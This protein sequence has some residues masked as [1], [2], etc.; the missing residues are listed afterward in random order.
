MSTPRLHLIDASGYIY[1]AFFSLPEMTNPA[2]QAVNA[3]YGFTRMIVSLVQRVEREGDGSGPDYLAAVFDPPG[4]RGNNF[5]REIDPNY[6]AARAP[7]KPELAGQFDLVREAAE[8]L[9][10]PVLGVDGF[11]ADDVLA[12]YAEEGRNS[13]LSVVVV[14]PDKDLMQLIADRNDAF[15]HGPIRMWDPLKGKEIGF[16]EV[17]EKFG[18]APFQVAC[19]QALAG[20]P[21]DNIPGVAGIG[22]K[23][24]SQMIRTAGSLEGALADPDRIAPTK[25]IA[26]LLRAFEADAVRSKKLATLR[27]DVP[28]PAPLPDLE[29][30]GFSMD[31]AIAFLE[32]HAFRSILEDLGAPV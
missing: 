21:T 6:K 20:D 30:A 32:R 2:G 4:G 13:G 1:R 19:V 22:I 8:A 17:Q 18:V 28:L 27:R 5:R 26:G 14:S 16:A 12:S 29:W 10:I 25:R 24:A 31:R 15:G 11:E 3:V 23:T 9:G 7:L